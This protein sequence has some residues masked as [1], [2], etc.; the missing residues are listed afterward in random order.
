MFARL[1]EKN[2]HKELEKQLQVHST[3]PT[4]AI[5][6]LRLAVSLGSLGVWTRAEAF[7]ATDAVMG[8][9]QRYQVS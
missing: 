5:E 7:L 9:S 2:F 4:K 8:K 3:E 6:G 1:Q